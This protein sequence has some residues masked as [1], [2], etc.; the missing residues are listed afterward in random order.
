M[1]QAHITFCQSVWLISKM[2]QWCTIIHVLGSPF[3]SFLQYSTFQCCYE[4]PVIYHTIITYPKS[5]KMTSK[6]QFHHE[7]YQPNYKLRN[8]TSVNVNERYV[9]STLNNKYFKQNQ[10][11]SYF[12]L[13][14]S[15]QRIMFISTYNMKKQWWLIN[16]VSHTL[17]LNTK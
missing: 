1:G 12:W 8:S 10:V 3:L 11:F 6:R 16:F 17:L 15:M 14:C 2:K 5:V 4:F 7:Q 9:N 13:I